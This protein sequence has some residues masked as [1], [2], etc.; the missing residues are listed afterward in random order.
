MCLCRE[1]LLNCVSTKIC[2]KPELMQLLTG[3]STKRYFPARGTAGF[4]RSLVKGKSRDPTPPPMMMES[5]LS[6]IDAE[7]TC[8]INNERKWN[9]FT[10]GFRA[11][12]PAKGKGDP[13]HPPPVLGAECGDLRVVLEC[14]VNNP[15]VIRVHGV[16]LQRNTAVPYLLRELTNPPN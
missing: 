8:I 9:R 4:E 14:I 13:L 7:A 15:P 11:S 6:E 3:I 12:S 5:V 2:R 10:G 16:Q 1:T